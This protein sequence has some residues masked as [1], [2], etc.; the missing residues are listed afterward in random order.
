MEGESNSLSASTCTGLPWH[1][2]VD[3]EGPS[4]CLETPVLCVS[5]SSVR[6]PSKRSNVT[7][8]TD[9][10]TW[11]SIF[12]VVE[13]RSICHWDWGTCASLRSG[14]LC[15]RSIANSN[16]MPNYGTYRIP[17]H[18]NIIGHRFRCCSL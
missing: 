12:H 17:V 9:E 8:A 2:R 11:E 1:I 6:S 16:T 15:F 5:Q 4:L 18:P 3:A 14:K 13:C 7:L 10:N